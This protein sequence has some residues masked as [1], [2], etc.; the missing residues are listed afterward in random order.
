M[1]QKGDYEVFRISTV[2]VVLLVLLSSLVVGIH[3]AETRYAVEQTT[4]EQ[5]NIV[6]SDNRYAQGYVRPFGGFGA[7]GASRGSFG[8][9]GEE[10]GA[11]NL[12][13]N[14]FI[15]RGRDPSKISNVYASA[16]GY[17]VINTYVEL[18]PVELQLTSRP[19]INGT[20][21]GYARLIFRKPHDVGIPE[22]NVFLRT[23]DLPALAPDFLY[24]AW[25][26]DEDTGTSASI[27]M[28]QPSA[29][30]RITTLDYKSTVPLAPFD[31]IIVTAE[32][33]PDDN[34]LPS[35]VILSASL[36][37]KKVRSP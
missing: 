10:E 26:V 5:R 19:Q 20:P 14:A 8:F 34:P 6:F 13:Y 25:L 24:Q 1:Y 4:I 35:Q 7:K 15:P 31:T 28:F 11:S 22:T 21:Q 23:R 30:S 12:P 2:G 27:G 16:R 29:I 9:K 36:K 32:P 17:Q 18:K 37:P 33:Y 3:T